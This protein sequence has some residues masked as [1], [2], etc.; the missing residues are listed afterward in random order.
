MPPAFHEALR[1][2]FQ[3]LALTGITPPSSWLQSHTILLY[4][5]GDPTR[6]D[7]YRPITLANVIYK[8]WT[9]CIVIFATDYIESRKF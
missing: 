9:T 2:L 4:K 7:I 1:L 8:L 3:A 5:K 6:L